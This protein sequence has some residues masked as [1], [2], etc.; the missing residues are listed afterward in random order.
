MRL[1]WKRSPDTCNLCSSQSKTTII[2]TQVKTTGAS[3]QSTS[4]RTKKLNL[5]C[6]IHT[7]TLWIATPSSS[8]H[9]KS[10]SLRISKRNSNQCSRK[11]AS[12]CKKSSGPSQFR[13][14]KKSTQTSGLIRSRKETSFIGCTSAHQ[15]PAQTTA[16]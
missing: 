1:R 5:K 15:I 14:T 12:L 4:Q 8:L 10:S 13:R 11:T 3:A 2:S 9:L 7:Q 16:K 6:Q